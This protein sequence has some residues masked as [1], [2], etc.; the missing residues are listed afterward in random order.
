MSAIE[1]YDWSKCH[2]EFKNLFHGYCLHKCLFNNN[3]SKTNKC[4]VAI[5]D[6]EIFN[7]SLAILSKNIKELQEGFDQQ[8]LSSK[9]WTTL[10]GNLLFSFINKW[11]KTAYAKTKEFK[12]MA[13]K[14][15]HFKN[16]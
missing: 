16:F 8:Q 6:N 9:M 2:E 3:C 10:T 11:D 15:K 7:E 4:C 1:K 12:Q 14:Y 5:T 13:I